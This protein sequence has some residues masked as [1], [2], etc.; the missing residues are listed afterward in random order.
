MVGENACWQKV[1]PSNQD[2]GKPKKRN[3]ENMRV[4]MVHLSFA[5]YSMLESNIVRYYRGPT[6]RTFLFSVIEQVN[7]W[8]HINIHN[9][10]KKYV[11]WCLCAC[12]RYEYVNCRANSNEPHRRRMDIEQ[13]SPVRSLNKSV[14]FHFKWRAFYAIQ[15]M[16]LANTHHTFNLIE[17][18][19]YG[20]EL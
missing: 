4:V 20:F 12:Y 15:S 19:T 13:N 2:R 8:I 10:S 9:L 11:C 7:Q 14:N 18:C 1:A 3:A 17:T 5:F 6:K 16:N